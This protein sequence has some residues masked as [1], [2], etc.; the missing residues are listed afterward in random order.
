M[1]VGDD[2]AQIGASRQTRDILSSLRANGHIRELR[3]GYLLGIAVAIAFGRQPRLGI[4][5]RET[6]FAA[7]G[8]DPQLW[9][10]TT[11]SEL[12][13]G[14]SATPYRAAED[15]AE[16]GLEIVHTFLDGDALW[17]GDL[18][19]RAARA[20]PDSAEAPVT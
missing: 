5:G 20:N 18:L 16:Q 3:D 17:Y 6:M 1:G 2:L 12:Y 4:G 11:V 14:V 8:L 19:D 13:P 9:I 7:G 10:R 15:L